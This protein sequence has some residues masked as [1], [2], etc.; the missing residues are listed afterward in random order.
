MSGIQVPAIQR[1]PNL[2]A[3]ALGW[4]NVKD[5]GATGDG[6]H[7]DAPAI[8]AAFDA[9][10][11]PTKGVLNVPPGLYKLGSTVNMA[12]GFPDAA[13]D[14][15]V[16][17]TNGEFFT[18]IGEGAFRPVAGIGDAIYISE[19]YYPQIRIRFDGGGQSGDHAL[20]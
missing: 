6:V 7:D 20:R 3:Q 15:T 5:F 4:I 11:S 12:L 8:Q 1:D 13:D 17:T 2:L 16:A 18:L 19:G 10:G 9:L 14:S